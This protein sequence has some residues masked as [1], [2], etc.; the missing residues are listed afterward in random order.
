[1][2]DPKLGSIKLFWAECAVESNQIDSNLVFFISH[3]PRNILEGSAE[4]I[5]EKVKIFANLNAPLA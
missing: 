5:Y 3:I 2:S 1:M 4:I